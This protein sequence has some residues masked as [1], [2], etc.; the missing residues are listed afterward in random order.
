MQRIVKRNGMVYAFFIFLLAFM[1]RAAICDAQNCRESG[2]SELFGL[3]Q[4]M[5]GDETTGIGLSMEISSS[6]GFGLGYGHNLNENLNINFDI[7][8]SSADITASAFGITITGDSSLISMHINLDYNILQ[9]RITPVITGGIGF[10]NFSS[11]FVGDTFDETDFSYNLGAGL[12]FDISENFFIKGF[13]RPIWTKLQD[14]DETI[15]LGGISIIL[16]YMF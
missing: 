11:D 9:S 12:R 2:G 10:I 15:M 16:G 1:M 4:Q 13:Y 8:F 7:F 14:T 3:I 5:N 6:T